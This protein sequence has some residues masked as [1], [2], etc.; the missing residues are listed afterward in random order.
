MAKTRGRAHRKSDRTGKPVHTIVRLEERYDE[1][2]ALRAK[3]SR[4]SHADWKPSN[5]RPDPI[6]L[7]ERSSAGRVLS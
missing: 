6:D 2:K 3:V 4:K 7:L 1:G 5:R